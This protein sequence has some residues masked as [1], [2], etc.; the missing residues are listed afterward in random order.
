MLNDPKDIS[1]GFAA[2][3]EQGHPDVLVRHLFPDPYPEIG[4]NNMPD[5]FPD[6]ALQDSFPRAFLFLL[7]A[8]LEYFRGAG[9][10]IIDVKEAASSEMTCHRGGYLPVLG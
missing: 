9:F 5:I 8:V 2:V 4:G 1:N 10:L 7:V 6:Q 3:G